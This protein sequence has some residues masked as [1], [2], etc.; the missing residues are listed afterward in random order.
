[1][2]NPIDPGVMHSDD[3]LLSVLAGNLGS[4]KVRWLH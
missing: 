2:A 4:E 3:A 1:M